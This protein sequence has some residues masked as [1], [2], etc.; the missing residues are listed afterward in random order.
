MFYVQTSVKKEKE[1]VQQIK[2]FIKLAKEI[3]QQDVA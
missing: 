3:S 1:Y 2:W